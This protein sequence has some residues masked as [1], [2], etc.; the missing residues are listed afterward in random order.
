MVMNGE[1][2]S[3]TGTHCPEDVD[4]SGLCYDWYQNCQFHLNALRKLP[5]HSFIKFTLNVYGYVSNRNDGCQH[6]TP[7]VYIVNSFLCFFFFF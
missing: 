6:P 7:A 2:I 3:V 5:G 4:L 1:R